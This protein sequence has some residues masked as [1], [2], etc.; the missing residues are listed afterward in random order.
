MS[1]EV[2]TQ[3]VGQ[4][5]QAI[6]STML[7]LPVQAL[8]HR[9]PALKDKVTSS[10]FLEGPWNGGVSLICS[11]PHA[12]QLA[13]RFLAADPPAEVDDDVRDVLGELANMIGG[14]IKSCLG[15]DM[16]LSLPSVIDGSDYEVRVCGSEVCDHI[17]FGSPDGEFWICIVGKCGSR[18]VRDKSAPESMVI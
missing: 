13:A 9:S 12:C 18:L 11:R 5:V 7:D 14:N 3:L 15:P 8:D 16:R 1:A 6:F 4:V 2:N 17:R 10:V